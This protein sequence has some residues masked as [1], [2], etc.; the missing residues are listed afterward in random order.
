MDASGCPEGTVILSCRL[1][2]MLS[3]SSSFNSSLADDLKNEVE[4]LYQ[5]A[6]FGTFFA[7]EHLVDFDAATASQR[8]L[9]REVLFL[10]LSQRIDYIIDEYKNPEDAMKVLRFSI[11][12]TQMHY[13][14]NVLML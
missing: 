12:Y 3:I 6:S 13:N 11:L 10:L 5:I 4:E 14:C 7:L 9:D 2:N 1:N 8:I